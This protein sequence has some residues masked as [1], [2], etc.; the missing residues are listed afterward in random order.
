MEDH[1]G[2]GVPENGDNIYNRALD[3]ASGAAILVELARTFQ[4]MNPA[5]R[6]STLFV[7]VA[8]EEAGLLGSDYFVHYPTVAKESM[9]ANLNLDEDLMLLP[10]E[11]VIAFGAEPSTLQGVMDWPVAPSDKFV[12]H[13]RNVESRIYL[14]KL[15][16]ASLA[17]R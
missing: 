4:Q 15:T 16:R 10:L 14:Q 12:G 6:R 8:G 9:A 7:A 3:N 13:K 2:I 1:L 5:P 11:D 17:V